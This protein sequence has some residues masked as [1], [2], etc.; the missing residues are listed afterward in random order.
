MRHWVTAVGFGL[1]GRAYGSRYLEVRYEDICANPIAQFERI[2][3]FLDVPF[4][5]PTQA[6]LTQSVHVTRVGKWRRAPP[7]DIDTALAIGEEL[8]GRLGY[9]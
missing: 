7:A 3:E 1:R 8:L 6:W 2:F 5:P 4:I 9:A